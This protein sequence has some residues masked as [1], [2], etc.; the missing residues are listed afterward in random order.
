MNLFLTKNLAHYNTDCLYEFYV[1]RI[2]VYDFSMY[3][4][5]KGGIL[6]IT[7]LFKNSKK[8]KNELWHYADQNTDTHPPFILVTIWPIKIA[9]HFG[10]TLIFCTLPCDPGLNCFHSR[11][12]LLFFHHRHMILSHIM[13]SAWFVS[14]YLRNY[15]ILQLPHLYLPHNQGKL[16]DAGITISSHTDEYCTETQ[17]L[18]GIQIQT[19]SY[20]LN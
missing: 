17:S 14:T 4:F 18:Y 2:D 16:A 20:F 11:H 13:L 3:G 7:F 19:N 12:G 10:T 5:F 6:F 1:Y 15:R 8:N 9:S